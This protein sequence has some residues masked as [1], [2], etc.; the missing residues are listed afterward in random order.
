MPVATENIL[1]FFGITACAALFITGFKELSELL[2]LL[3]VILY[4]I[5]VSYSKK[6]SITAL[7]QLLQGSFTHPLAAQTY[8]NDSSALSLIKVAIKS[9]Q[10]HLRTVIT[11]I[12]DAA[13]KVAAESVNGHELTKITLHEIERQQSETFQVATAMNQMSTTIGEV[14]KHVADTAVCAEQANQLAEQGNTVAAITRQSIEKL[15]LTVSEISASV[16]QVSEQTAKIATAAQMIEQI[17]DQTNLLALNA[18]IEAAR[19]GEQGR[20]FAVVAD[21]VRNLAK[22][23]QQSTGEIYAI[24]QQLI[25][26]ASGAVQ[27]AE[28]GNAAAEQGVENVVKSADMLAGISDAVSQITTMSTQMAAAVEEQAHVAEDI[29]RQIVSISELASTSSESAKNTSGSIQA[30]RLVSDA[31][32][33][34]VL[35]FSR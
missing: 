24:V 16:S 21:E 5:T 4:A 19:A 34:L 15:K 26:S 13:R 33:E 30:L 23:T 2:L 22:R 27:I 1:L 8:T 29:N 32:N 14:S 18:A 28:L 6:N 31:L 12:E 9:Q 25:K 35:R 20:G 17:A 10:A 3:A 11:R 7:Q